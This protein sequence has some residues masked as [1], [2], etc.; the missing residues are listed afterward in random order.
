MNTIWKQTAQQL[1]SQR[2]SNGW[3]YIQLIIIFVVMWF[4]VDLMWD[5]AITTFQPRGVEIED[6]YQVDIAVNMKL[7]ND[8]TLTE[9][10]EDY[11]LEM[12]RQIKE[13]PEVE[14]V[15]YYMGTR[16]YEDN[17]MMEVYANERD[18]SAVCKA[19]IRYISAGYTD[20]FRIDV[21]GGNTDNWE[22]IPYPRPAL[23]SGDMAGI[24]FRDQ[25]A[26]GMRFYNYYAN[27]HGKTENAYYV[28]GIL[29]PTKINE[30]YV[31]EPFIYVY[32]EPE[33]L[34]YS[35]P[36]V[37]LRVRP[38]TPAGFM[39][40]F[41]RDMK[42]RL[43]VGPYYMIG[44]QSYEEKKEVFAIEQGH[45]AYLQLSY[46]ISTFFICNVFFALIGTFWFRTRKRRGEIG[47]RMAMGAT[48]RQVQHYILLEGL[49]LFTLAA[50]P[51][52]VVCLNMAYAD[53]NVL[54]LSPVTPFRY[55]TTIFLTYIL[56]AAMV[57]IGC[58]S[59]AR[60]AMKLKP[61]EALH[62]E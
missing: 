20:V 59:P 7:W 42:S 48:R 27:K 47:L 21:Q 11:F 28:S 16:L 58:W 38:G 5:Y 15:C 18:T 14:A 3:L 44:I 2:R 32:L 55:I 52:I 49:M 31:Y 54:A 24:L 33:V 43:R 25:S 46:G 37:A 53:L 50:I 41:L 8:T 19:K 35:L 61:A 34:R 51:A 22:H 36:E 9:K 57:L 4:W 6:V 1:W 39:E 45:T 23:I 12:M 62:D 30:F 56:I 26:V 13:Y 10:R 17:W 40:K 29:P 60:Y